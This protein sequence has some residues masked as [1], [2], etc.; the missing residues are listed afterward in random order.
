M[1][2]LFLLFIYPF[3]T[4]LYHCLTSQLPIMRFY[5]YSTLFWLQR[6]V[7][8]ERSN[9]KCTTVEACGSPLSSTCIIVFTI[10]CSMIVFIQGK[11]YLLLKITYWILNRRISERQLLIIFNFCMYIF[12]EYIM[13]FVLLTVI[14]YDLR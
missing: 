13:Y 10:L 7:V 6:C 8:N 9:S 5:G 4:S 14:K 3:I 11:Q 1:L 2:T 12:C